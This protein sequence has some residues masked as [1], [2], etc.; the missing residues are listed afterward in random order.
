MIIIQNYY[1]AVVLCVLAMV[2]WGSWQNTQ[3]LIGRNWRFE[4]YYWDFVAGILLFSLI[5]A[6]TIGSLGS[7]GRTFLQD[8]RQAD[9]GPLLSS[10]AGG[11]IW[12][13]GTLLL[14]A[15]ISIA[16]MSV[17]FPIGG[18][19]G[20]L[21]GILV[22][23][24]PEQIKNPVTLFTGMG[25]IV[26]AILLS[27][28]SYQ[29]LSAQTK[30]PTL[31]GILLSFSAGL[32]IAMFYRFVAGSLAAYQVNEAGILA[33]EAGKLSPYTSVVLFSLGAF[34]STFIFNPV[35]MKKPVQGEPVKMSAYFTGGSRA[36]LLGILGGF[37]WCT[38]NMASVM[39]AN[40]ASPAISYGL[41]NAA[42]VVAAIWGIFVWKEFREAPRKTN[43]ILTGMFVAYLAGLVLITY[44]NV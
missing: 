27:M 36:H 1:L 3:N 5:A 24:N 11:A 34:L 21:L 33:L 2:C 32:L 39:A 37:I 28:K 10:F 4:L 17:A 44:A 42:P 6:F 41:S 22:N 35:F 8:L 29:M 13:L 30:K 26:V 14:I 31:K 25:I 19:I 43:I 23:Y 38:G 9:A 16:G 40:A 12:N 20:W 15:A 7:Q 18:G